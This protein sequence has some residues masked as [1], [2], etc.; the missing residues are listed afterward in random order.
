M[1]SIIRSRRSVRTFDGIPLKPET[2]QEILDYA[3]SVVNPY[4][5]S[6]QW[7]LLDAGKENLKC[8]VITGTDIYI[9]GK[10]KKAPHGEE[11]FGYA[12]EKVVLFAESKG[13]GTTWIG[14][15]MDRKAF[16]KAIHL[17][18]DEVMPCVSP[19][20]VPADKMAI[21]ETLMRKAV[22]ADTRLPLSDLVFD[23]DF[24]TPLSS[25][26]Y[27]DLADALEMVRWAPSAVNKQPWRLVLDGSNVHFFEKKSKGYVDA[28][29]WDMQKIDLGIALSHF[30]IGLREIGR[31]CDFILSDPGIS[32]PAD[33]DYIATLQ[34]K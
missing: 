32:T 22:K 5:L 21:K 24:D 30:E 4:G 6:I 14:G 16:E 1:K 20:G 11:A 29:G 13:L 8:P 34:L 10:M 28:A 23:K 18:S 9:A 27:G 26:R 25:E 7:F 15:T 3:N 12:F 2:A 19:L 33:T 17:G 31:S